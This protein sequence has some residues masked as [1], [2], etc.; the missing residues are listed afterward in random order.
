MT[1]N[2]RAMETVAMATADLFDTVEA[3][4]VWA[5]D[6]Y[7]AYINEYNRYNGI[8]ADADA[9]VE[10]TEHNYECMGKTYVAK[11]LDEAYLMALMEFGVDA[12]GANVRC[13]DNSD[14]SL[15]VCLEAYRR[16]FP[17]F[18]DKDFLAYELARNTAWVYF[19]KVTTYDY[20]EQCEVT[21]LDDNGK[22]YIRDISSLARY[23]DDIGFQW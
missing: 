13:L 14:F 7:E 2:L 3:Y 16:A 18:T 23:M 9:V 22:A 19:D 17:N 20:W 11:S 1:R 4:D 5:V 10:A 15:N 6:E 21:T 12:I 8:T